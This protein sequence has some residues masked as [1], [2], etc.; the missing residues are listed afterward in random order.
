MI[1]GAAL[2]LVALVGL[3]FKSRF[4]VRLAAGSL[5]I[6]VLWK[7]GEIRGWL[8]DAKSVAIMYMVSSIFA[9]IVSLT[10]PSRRKEIRPR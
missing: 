1:L 9:Y 2:I 5:A 4:L 7:V 6:T 3:I 8:M 10:I